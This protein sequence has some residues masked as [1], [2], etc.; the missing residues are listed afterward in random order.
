MFLDLDRFKVINDS[1]GH[2]AGDRLLVA[3]AERLTGLVRPHDIVGRLSADEFIVVL[4]DMATAA[5]VAPL[6][7]RLDEALS[8]PFQLDGGDVYL[9]ASVGVAHSGDG[10]SAAQL[11]EQADAAMYRAKELGRDRLEVF[12]DRLR[13]RARERL[14]LEQDLRQAIDEGHLVVH[15]QPGIELSSGRICG[16]EAL[17][18]WQHAERGLLLP[19]DF[20]PTAEATGL[21]VPIGRFVLEQAVS[22]ARNWAQHLPD[23]DGFMVAVNFSARELNSP[24]MAE[25]VADVLDRHG[26]P[27][28]LLS[29]ELTESIL[30]E[31]AD[32]ALRTLEQLKEIGVMLAIDDFGT[33]YSSLSY[34]HRFPVDIVKIDRAF[35]TPLR[36]DGG[37]SAVTTAVMHMADAL[38]IRTSAEGVETP[39]QLE[40]LRKLRCHSAQGFLFS[41]A[42]PAKD[43][44]SML[45]SKPAW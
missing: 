21:I 4:P 17:L 11:L 24:G 7:M 30:I 44:R 33:G 27:P 41:K 13:T 8:E 42:V 45:E 28:E 19:G 26:W 35:I 3:F 23:L 15:Y 37:G 22:Q 34:L 10:A 16:V 14:Q 39:E 9:S 32:G 29:M 36:A 25:Q 20:I 40:G 43:L 38:E 5:E 1:M 18:R 12:D 2:S 31:D 6:A